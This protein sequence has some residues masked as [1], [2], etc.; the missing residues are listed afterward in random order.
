M[1][2]PHALVGLHPSAYLNAFPLHSVI[3]TPCPNWFLSDT[4][5]LVFCFCI[6]L[7][8]ILLFL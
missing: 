3:L 8:F 7:N 6:F 4:C 1:I 2:Y 5:Y